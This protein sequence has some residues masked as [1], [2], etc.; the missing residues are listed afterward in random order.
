MCGGISVVYTVAWLQKYL[1]KMTYLI[2]IRVIYEIRL[3]LLKTA[4]GV[5][6]PL[7]CGVV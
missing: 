4:D 2:I 3:K 7:Y 5:G 1:F 6:P